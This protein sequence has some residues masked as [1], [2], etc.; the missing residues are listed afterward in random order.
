M[1]AAMNRGRMIK[2]ALP[3]LLGIGLCLGACT[4][5]PDDG[6]PV[7]PY[8]DPVYGSLDFDYGGWGGGWHHGWDHGRGFHGAGFHGGFGHGFAGHGGFGGHGGG[9]G[10]R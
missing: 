8:P 4:V 2:K 7:Y 9:G 3:L 5:E 6:V 10:H 1:E